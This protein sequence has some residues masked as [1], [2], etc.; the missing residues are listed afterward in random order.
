MMILRRKFHRQRAFVARVFRGLARR[1]EVNPSA[2]QAG[3]QWVSPTMPAWVR[4]EILALSHIEPDL[5]DADDKVDRYAFYSVPSNPVPGEVYTDLLDRVGDHGYTHVLLLPW[6]KPGGADRG[7]LYHMRAILEAQPAARILVIA[8]E[9]AESPWKDRVPDGVT[10]VEFGLLARHIDFQ[11]QVSVLTRLLVQLRPPVA[12]IINSRVGWEAIKW[13]GLALRQYTHWFASLF[14]DDYTDRGVA[15]GYARSY[16]RD[17]YPYFDRIFCDNSRYPRTWTAEI[18]VP[19]GV[20]DVLPFPYD[21][22]F[23]RRTDRT[24]PELPRILW[25]GRLDRQKRPD[26]LAR[27][28]RELPQFHFDVHGGS[29]IAGAEAQAGE[30]KQLPNVTLHGMFQRLEDIVR[31]DH[32]AYLHTTAWEGL[33]TILFDVAAAGI[34]II[35]PAVGG[36]PDFVDVRSLV[37]NH[38]DVDAFVEQLKLLASSAEERLARRNAQYDELASTRRWEVFIARISSVAGYLARTNV[39]RAEYAAGQTS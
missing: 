28:A 33:P 1:V 23:V 20:F 4:D 29:V 36:I 9:P 37:A 27:I 15:V 32:I 7:A 17:C 24:E 3:D 25:A 14:C 13:H 6:L 2:G 39:V 8:T 30:L 10:Y 12:H 5:L 22:S 16:L 26:L 35:A 21:R 38:E 11:L 34:P 18:G 19:S 31:P